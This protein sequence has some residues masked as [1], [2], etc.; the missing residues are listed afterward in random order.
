MLLAASL[1]TL[2]ALLAA[3][4]GDG[5]DGATVR[6]LGAD[7]STDASSGSGS[8]SGSAS[9]PVA[10]GGQVTVGDGGYEYAS[11]VDS[12][13]LLVADICPIGGLLD[14]GDFEAV[15]IIYTDGVNSINSDGSVRTIGGFAASEDRLHGLATYYGTATP[16]DALSE[17]HRPST[18]AL[19]RRG[20]E[21]A[22]AAPAI[23]VRSTRLKL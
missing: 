18:S 11:D 22:A 21:Q 9:A 17:P 13:R 19:R 15:A 2:V 3:S 23:L 10:A 4:C 14:E 16:L 1:I 12:H 7:S 5:D 6:D 8:A 20:R